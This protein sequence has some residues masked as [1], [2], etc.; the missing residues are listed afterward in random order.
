VRSADTVVEPP[1]VSFT[2]SVP[3]T[4]TEPIALEKYVSW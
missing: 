3:S 4:V 2:D 1:V